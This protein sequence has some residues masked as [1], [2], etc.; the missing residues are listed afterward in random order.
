M[1]SFIFFSGTNSTLD[2]HDQETRANPPSKQPTKSATLSARENET[3]KTNPPSKQ[4]TKLVTRNRESETTKVNLHYL[5][6]PKLSSPEP[7]Q[8]KLPV[9]LNSQVERYVSKCKGLFIP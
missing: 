8:L 4:P 5:Q 2:N 6:Y 1:K 3:T 9:G 7:P